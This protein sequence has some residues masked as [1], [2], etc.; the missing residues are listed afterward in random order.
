MCAHMQRFVHAMCHCL[1]VVAV[2]VVSPFLF[3]CR[4][5]VF[6]VV[7][8]L[9]RCRNSSPCCD[10]SRKG[11]EELGKLLVLKLDGSCSTDEQK[12][13]DKA[14]SKRIVVDQFIVRVFLYTHYHTSTFPNN[15]GRMRAVLEID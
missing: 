12:P 10:T 11:E 1:H 3:L 8:L 2:V 7:I 5:L 14:H 13:K 6:V 9:R 4:S 15:Y